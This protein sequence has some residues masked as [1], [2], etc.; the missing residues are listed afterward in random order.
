M[1]FT[2]VADPNL[3]GAILEKVLKPDGTDRLPYYVR[4][5][6]TIFYVQALALALKDN[7]L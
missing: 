3:K 2:K 1:Q 4:D 7:L 5:L 6:G